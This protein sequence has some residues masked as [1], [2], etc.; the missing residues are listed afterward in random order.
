RID[1]AGQ[2]AAGFVSHQLCSAAFVSGLDPEQYYREAIAPTLQPVDFLA[3]RSVDGERREGAGSFAGIA[4]ARAVYRGQF[5]CL[6]TS[7]NPPA[8]GMLP[9]EKPAPV[10]LPEIAS[11]S[12]VEPAQPALRAAL[13]RTFQENVRPPF[14]Q[15]KA[16]VVVHDGRVIAERYAPGYGID[17]PLL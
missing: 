16:V 2:V 6:V 4:S 15:T 5:G 17:T 1:G 9:Q 8:T 10:L 7:G 11:P 12:V 14:R 13:D 3:G